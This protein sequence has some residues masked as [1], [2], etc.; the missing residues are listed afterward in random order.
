MF[1]HVTA[2]EFGLADPENEQWL[3]ESAQR[4]LL[5]KGDFFFVPPGNVYRSVK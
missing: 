4:I 1:H 3:D 5:S 2:V